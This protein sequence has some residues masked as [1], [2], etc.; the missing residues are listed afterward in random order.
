MRRGREA[1]RLENITYFYPSSNEPA[2]EDVSLQ[3]NYGEFAVIAG[4]SG[5]GKSTL[6]RIITGLI[7]N[8]YGGKLQG[9]AYVDGLDVAE[10]DLKNLIEKVGVVLQNPENQIVN[11]V[12]E[13]EIAFALE[14]LVYSRDTIR[15]RVEEVVKRLGVEHL[16][17]R[18]TYELSGGEAQKV[19]LGSILAVKP[20]IL[21]LDEPLAHLDPYSSRELVEF[22]QY[23]N[24]VE[25]KTIVVIEHRLS[26]LLKYATRLVVLDR[27]V[28]FDGSPREVLV[29]MNS[30]DS[31]YGIEVPAVSKLAKAIDLKVLPLGVDEA[32]TTVRVEDIISRVKQRYTAGLSNHDGNG[33]HQ[34][35]D[36]AVS[37]QGLW[38]IY[39]S[40]VEALRG[41]DLEICRGE[42]VAIVG[43]N[44]SG[45]TTL[46]KH[47][48]GL[49]KPT[50]G[51]VFVL[52]MDVSRHSVAELAR[53]VGLVFQ[54]P[55]HHFFKETIYE[56][57]VFTAKNMG[58][59]NVGERASEILKKFYLLHL[60]DRS[61]YE[62]SAGEQRRLAIASVLVYEPEIVVLDEPTAGIDFRLKLE[63]LDVLTKIWR[64][65]KTVVITSHDMEFLSY[66]PVQK[67]V[68]MDK[69]EVVAVGSFR[70]ILYEGLS[71]E[72]DVFTPQIVRFAKGLHLESILGFRPLNVVDLI[73]AIRGEDTV[74]A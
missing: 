62:I 6:C 3:I 21:V 44:G 10:I 19:V 50:K 28:L 18:A 12:V 70:K 2:L 42:F 9:R 72:L 64:S 23:L 5:G 61:P 33:V 11:L 52:G 63:L 27:K 71:E 69:G 67:I 36:V 13:E 54:N 48:N 29:A 53:H 55:L 4:P 14:N 68:V 24:K 20:K 66:T 59:A 26:E 60:A 25:D 51:R 31:D 56:E 16:R 22:L 41:I 32:L 35:S 7:P 30:V 73:R 47:F 46:V 1:I 49:L 15:A 38:H 74:Q 65:G 37:V 34:C 40:G 39:E 45:K 58:V 43:G 8:L 17:N 57:I